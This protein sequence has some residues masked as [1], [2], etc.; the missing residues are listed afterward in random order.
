MFLK[1]NVRNCHW[2]GWDTE[3][4]CFNKMYY[5]FSPDLDIYSNII[6]HDDSA[7][8]YVDI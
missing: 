3:F 4:R 2:S 5:I 6:R 8:I 7:L 1:Q